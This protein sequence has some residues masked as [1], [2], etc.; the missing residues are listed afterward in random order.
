MPII[1]YKS[2][3]VRKPVNTK[4]AII[5]LQLRKLLFWWKWGSRVVSTLWSWFSSIKNYTAHYYNPQ[6]IAENLRISWIIVLMLYVSTPY[7]LNLMFDIMLKYHVIKCFWIFLF[8]N[9]KLCL[10]YPCL[11]CRSFAASTKQWHFKHPSQVLN[12]ND[13]QWVS[14]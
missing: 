7:Y 5:Y 8:K 10:M 3:V 4:H 13:R 11:F 1:Q 9:L 12:S 6:F 2:F 14:K